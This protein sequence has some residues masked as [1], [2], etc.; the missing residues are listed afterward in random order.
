M[1]LARADA[2]GVF[3][4]IQNTFETYW[5]SPAFEIYTLED[6]GRL[7]DALLNAK[8]HAA[9]GLSKKVAKAIGEL[10]AQLEDA[11]ADLNLQAKDYQKRMLDKLDVRRS[12]FDEHRHLIVAATGTENGDGGARLR[13]A[14]PAGTPR[15][16]LLFVAHR[17]QILDQ[18]R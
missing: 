6:R 8:G 12:E 13:P 1:R 17:E 4:R 7:D 9:E 14:V 15:P 11:Y 3:Q 18:A 16:T 2:P 10:Q 5:Q